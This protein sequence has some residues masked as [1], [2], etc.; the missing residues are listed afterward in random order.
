MSIMVYPSSGRSSFAVAKVGLTIN[1][2]LSVSMSAR[3]LSME[4]STVLSVS[5]MSSGSV[6]PFSSGVRS[7]SLGPAHSMCSVLYIYV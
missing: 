2:I 7:G 4:F 1:T 5:A 3:V 6:S